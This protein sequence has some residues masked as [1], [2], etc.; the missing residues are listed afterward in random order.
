MENYPCL[1]GGKQRPLALL[2]QDALQ[3]PLFFFV[4]VYERFS[5]VSEEVKWGLV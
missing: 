5:A 4:L 3:S 1:L 2:L